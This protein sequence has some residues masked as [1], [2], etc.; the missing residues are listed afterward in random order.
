M[1]LTIL[2]HFPESSTHITTKSLFAILHRILES[3]LPFF[4]TSRPLRK[5]RLFNV[6]PSAS[7]VLA[8]F[9]MALDRGG[10]GAGLA[11]GKNWSKVRN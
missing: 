8:C 9:P 2:L 4:S 10:G 7:E 1:P 5:R 3:R 11:T 6:I